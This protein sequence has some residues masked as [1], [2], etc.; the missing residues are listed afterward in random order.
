MLCR[1]AGHTPRRHGT[2]VACATTCIWQA[3]LSHQER[4]WQAEMDDAE[5][6]QAAELGTALATM[7]AAGRDEK[8]GMT[9]G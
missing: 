3:R 5:A 7:T 8:A 4:R 9:G 2:A 6:S 1:S